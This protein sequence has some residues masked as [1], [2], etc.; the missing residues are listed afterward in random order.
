MGSNVDDD[1]EFGENLDE[2]DFLTAENSAQ[3]R[4]ADEMN[5]HDTPASKRTKLDGDDQSMDLSNAILKRIWGFPGFRLKQAAAVS[6]LLS[7]RNALVVFPTGGGKSLVYQVPALAFDEHDSGCG[8]SQGGGL[9]LV[10]S[11]LI[12]LM[13]VRFLKPS[14][15]RWC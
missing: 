5:D 1:D 13:K 4:V 11:P 7:G 8:K 10:I 3:K 6:H 12:A 9:T 15:R 14:F 2:T